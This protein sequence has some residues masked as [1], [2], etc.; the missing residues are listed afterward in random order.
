M[1]ENVVESDR[2]QMTIIWRMRMACSITKATDTHSEYLILIAFPRQK[3][4]HGR[5]FMLRLSVYCLY[6]WFCTISTTG[7]VVL[8]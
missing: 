4:L 8:R 3:W 5:A 2:S 7:L 1:C 6:C